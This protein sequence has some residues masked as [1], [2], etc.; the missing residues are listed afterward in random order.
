MERAKIEQIT[1][2]DPTDSK[3]LANPELAI[4]P[5]SERCKFAK[6]IHTKRCIRALQFMRP[7][8]AAAVTRTF[9][10]KGWIS[11]TDR[12]PALP[13]DRDDPANAFRE[14]MDAMEDDP[15]EL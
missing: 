8:V 7:A 13:T 4:L 11:E 10:L 2:F 15:I 1:D 3:H 12:I 14:T 6:E 9:R 5:E